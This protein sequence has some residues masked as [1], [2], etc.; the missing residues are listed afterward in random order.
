MTFS[1]I[2]NSFSPTRITPVINDALDCWRPPA[3][4]GIEN[5]QCGNGGD[6]ILNLPIHRGGDGLTRDQRRDFWAAQRAMSGDRRDYAEA[7]RLL[8]PIAAALGPDNSYGA[9]RYVLCMY[10]NALLDGQSVTSANAEQLRR[11]LPNLQA[12]ADL[13]AANP[14]DASAHERGCRAADLAFAQCSLGLFHTRDAVVR[15]Q[16]LERGQANYLNSIQL[17]EGED[18]AASRNMLS[19][20][21][22]NYVFVLR[23]LQR[24]NPTEARG[25]EI[26]RRIAQLR[27]LNERRAQDR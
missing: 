14:N 10:T 19:L 21:L 25:Q 4:A 6:D 20:T 8:A 16:L 22:N 1:E 26:E 27:N 5:Q 18:S 9:Q 12:E 11:A 2:N 3:A 13:A 15:Q 24:A 17:L 7:R 23:E